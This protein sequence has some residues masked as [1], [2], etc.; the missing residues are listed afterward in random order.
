MQRSTIGVGPALRKARQLRGVTVGEASRDT[1]LR[2]ELLEALEEE[3]FERLPGD[4]YVRGCLRSYSNYL[5]LPADAVVAAYAKHLDEPDLEPR[6]ILP[7][8]EPAVGAK[9]RRD[10]T[11]LWIMSAATVL[12]LAGAF[13]VLSTREA[14]PPPAELPTQAPLIAPA[15]REIVVAVL[16][17][18]DVEVTIQIDGG[19]PETFALRPGESR[20]FS[21]ATSLTVRLDHGESARVTVGGRDLGFPGNPTHPWKKTFSFDTGGESPPPAG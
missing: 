7:P 11:R 9:R 20:S 5:G 16:A 3:E 14:A 12:L 1:K 17:K 21:A 6:A 18:D 8:T 15:S 2:P 4:V 13:G 10:N 19:G